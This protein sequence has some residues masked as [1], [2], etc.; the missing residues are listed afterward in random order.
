MN[1]SVLEILKCPNCGSTSF[2]SKILSGS[3]A[4]IE[5]G[6]LW[7]KNRHWF[8]IER[9]VLEFLPADLQY[10]E[11]RR[12]FHENHDSEMAPCGLSGDS[13][14]TR[15][16]HND[17]ELKLIQTQQHHF[18]WY[19][20]NEEQAYNA[21]AAM[22]FWRI[23]DTRTFASWNAKISADSKT[24]GSTKLI[25]DVGCAQGR[26]AL[27]IAQP[28]VRVIGFDVSKQLV[29]QA[30]ANFQQAGHG[31][32]N[33]FIVADGS[34][35]PFQDGVFDY[36]LVYGVLHH[37]PDPGDACREIVRVL[38]GGGTYFG[39]ENNK[40]IFRKIFDLLQKLIPAWHEEAGKQPLMSSQD[41]THW[42]SD[43]NM[44][45]QTRST[46]FVP[47]H[48]V[49]LLGLKIGGALISASD[50]ILTGLPFLKHQGGLVLVEGK[51]AERLSTA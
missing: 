18:D 26:S 32:G 10:A 39:S 44:A 37:L 50:A 15:T 41:F 40:T 25:L 23:V 7:C 27:M 17:D 8:P 35:F 36:A 30:Y 46:V 19:A 22:P 51:K 28:G 2:A 13:T 31:T 5:E 9:R 43:T 20:A 1:S 45:I 6:F 49:N 34:R 48:L 11:D 21:Y 24:G 42:F 38:K 16:G 29:R 4:D 12:R 14:D 47:P 3:A 33:D